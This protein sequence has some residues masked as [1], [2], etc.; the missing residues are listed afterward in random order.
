MADWLGLT[1]Q[2]IAKYEQR[3]VTKST[4]LALSAMDRGLQPFKPT[5]QDLQAVEVFERSGK[6]RV[7]EGR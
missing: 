7:K 6:T 1:P 4:A 3:G 5:R 2:A